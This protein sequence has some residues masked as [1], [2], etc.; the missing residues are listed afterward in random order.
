VL[1]LH[2]KITEV[3]AYEVDLAGDAG[4]RQKATFQ[5]TSTHAGHKANVEFT[6]VDVRNYI[7]AKRQRSVMYDDV[8]CVS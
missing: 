6:Q 8:G 5:L 3:Q 2:R 7:T 4:L 1:Q